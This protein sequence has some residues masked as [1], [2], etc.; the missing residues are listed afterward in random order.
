MTPVETLHLATF[1]ASV[2]PSVRVR[3]QFSTRT[4]HALLSDVDATDALIAVIRLAERQ[5]DIAVGDIHAEA[6]RVRAERLTDDSQPD[7]DPDGPRH[8]RTRL[9]AVVT[10]MLSLRVP[11]PWCGAAPEQPCTLP[12]GAIPLRR[13]PAHPARLTAVGPVL[14]QRP[15]GAQHVR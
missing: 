6:H 2:Y 10:A 7:A 13:T 1:L 15:R 5:R 9:P 12:G 11:C 8:F 4:W 3:E 14:T